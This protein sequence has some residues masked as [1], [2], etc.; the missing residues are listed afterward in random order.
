MAKTLID[1]LA[2]FWLFHAFGVL[3]R[4]QASNFFKYNNDVFNSL[5]LNI[6]TKL[7]F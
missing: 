1:M 5:F 2:Y 4:N 3:W 6:K 7:L